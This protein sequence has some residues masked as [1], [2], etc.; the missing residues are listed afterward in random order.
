MKWYELWMV[1][2]S[3]DLG[4]AVLILGVIN[5]RLYRKFRRQGYRLS[6]GFRK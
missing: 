2:E 6:V 1:Y 4:I 3:I 5:Y